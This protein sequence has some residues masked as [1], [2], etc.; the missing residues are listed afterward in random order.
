MQR[1][2]EKKNYYFMN[3]IIRLK[4]FVDYKHISK[5]KFYKD[6]GFSNGYLDK[7]SSIGSD[8]CEII[9]SCFPD[10]SIDWL[11]TGKGNMLKSEVE[12]GAQPVE[13]PKP[14]PPPTQQESPDLLDS[15]LDATKRLG[16][17]ELIVEQLQ[18]SLT[19]AE[20]ALRAS[21]NLIKSQAEQIKEDKRIIAGLN[22]AATQPITQDAATLDTSQA[23][24]LQPPTKLI[25]HTDALDAGCAA[26]T[27]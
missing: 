19:K 15:L 1:I 7:N 3:A 24:T 5:Y 2:N 17:A 13:P 10:L 23:P 21:E 4:Q 9:S 8:K 26:A 27:G 12:Q 11:I 18:S 25:Y 20:I 16:R 14:E 22:F 6:T